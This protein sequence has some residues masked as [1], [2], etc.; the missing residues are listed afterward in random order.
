VQHCWGDIGAST[1]C[2]KTAVGAASSRRACCR[3]DVRGVQAM[4]LLVEMCSKGG[5]ARPCASVVAARAAEEPTA[6]LS[7]ELSWGER[8]LVFTVLASDSCSGEACIACFRAG[9]AR[10]LH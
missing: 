8:E 9:T 6:M 2:H 1:S 7:R 3:G 10:L 5:G 4:E